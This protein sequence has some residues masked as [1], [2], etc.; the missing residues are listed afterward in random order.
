[1]DWNAVREKITRLGQRE[2][3]AEWGAEEE[4]AIGD[5]YGW[6]HRYRLEAPIVADEIVTFERQHGITLPEDYRQFLTQVGN[7]GAGPDYG[8]YSLGEGEEGPLPA[9]VLENLP[10]EFALDEPW[11]DMD[12]LEKPESYYS[13]ELLAGAIPIATRG[14]AL[15]YWMVVSGP[16]RGEIWLD[17]RTD[18]EGVEPI[19]EV[20]GLH[21]TFG[22]WYASWLEDACTKHSII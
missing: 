16:R 13:Y 12:L 22:L 21:M 3:P 17:K 2:W 11:N 20:D 4:T 15:D 9:I 8:I 6:C 19:C 7:G 1:M 10:V 5:Y 18:G 14:C